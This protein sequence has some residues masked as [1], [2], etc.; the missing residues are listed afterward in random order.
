MKERGILFSAEMVR[1]I[2]DGRKSMTRRAVNLETLKVIPRHKVRGD[3]IYARRMVAGGRKTR[4]Q[5]NPQ[6]AV[7]GLATDGE[8]LGLKPEEFD[9]VCPY[10]DGTTILNGGRWNILPSVGQR[11]W[12][13]ESGYL[14][15]LVT[16]KMLRDGADTWPQYMYSADIESKDNP[17]CELEWLRTMKWKPRPSIYMPRWA[18][19][20][21][22]EIEDVRVER[23]QDITEEDAVS[24]GAAFCNHGVEH[25][26]RHYLCSFRALWD[27]TNAKRP[28]CA[29]ADNPWVWVIAFRRIEP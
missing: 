17:K 22:L 28:G 7:S 2:L 12:G 10:C 24:E 13:R 14:P 1:A 11:L 25:D 18:S 9:F 16:G 20:I 29:W 4:A 8:W 21:T 26:G 23:L 5:L 27:S 3:L 15:P 6:G 19:R